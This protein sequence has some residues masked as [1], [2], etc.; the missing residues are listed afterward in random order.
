M[1]KCNKCKEKS[2]LAQIP[3]ISHEYFMFKAYRRENRLKI[4]LTFSV[5]INALLLC[6]I[7]LKCAG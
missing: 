2:D 3:Y 4:L 5:I 6:A 1:T 7:I